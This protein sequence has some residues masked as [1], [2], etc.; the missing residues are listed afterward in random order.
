M[1]RGEKKLILIAEDNVIIKLCLERMFETIGFRKEE[2]VFVLNGQKAVDIMQ[3]QHIDL[4][5][6]VKLRY[7]SAIKYQISNHLPIN[8]LMMF[9][10]DYVLFDN[11]CFAT[12][13][14]RIS[15][16]LFL[17]DILLLR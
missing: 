3:T 7:F 1:I 6:M 10:L 12:I 5:L 8:F 16:C 17:M 14:F 11:I 9:Y 13:L 4:V 2:M 15:T